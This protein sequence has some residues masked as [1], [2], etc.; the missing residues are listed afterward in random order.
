M[1]RELRPGAS[2]PPERSSR[3]PSSVI[4][5]FDYR[6]KT[7]EL[8]V[9][10]VSGRRYVYFGV[11]GEEVERLQTAESKG[12]YFNLQ[13]RDRYRYRELERAGRR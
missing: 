10:F 2:P 6:P 11:P 9:Q 12:R 4:R 3:M 8:E 1:R 5:S 7:R 13:I